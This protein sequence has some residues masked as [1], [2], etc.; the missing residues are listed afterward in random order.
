[1]D[2]ETQQ[3]MRFFSVVPIQTVP[4]HPGAYHQ[5]E[6]EFIQSTYDTT[7]KDTEIQ[8]GIT[9]IKNDKFEQFFT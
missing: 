1:M 9:R 6:T 4:F 2:Q 5:Q 7:Q 8:K 3:L